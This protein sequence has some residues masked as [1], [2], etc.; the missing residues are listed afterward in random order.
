MAEGEGRWRKIP[1]SDPD[2]QEVKRG[3]GAL[4]EFTGF[5]VFGSSYIQWVPESGSEDHDGRW[6][7]M[8]DRKLSEVRS[9]FIEFL[10]DDRTLIPAL[11]LL[12]EGLD[13]GDLSE[14]LVRCSPALPEIPGSP[15]K[16]QKYGARLPS[17]RVARAIQSGEIPDELFGRLIQLHVENFRRKNEFFQKNLPQYL[18]RATQI[19]KEVTASGSIPISHEK[20]DSRIKGLNIRLGDALFARLGEYYGTFNIED[21]GI[22]IA[23]NIPSRMFEHAL[24]HEMLHALSGR[25]VIARTVKYEEIAL[26]S[27]EYQAQRGGLMFYTPLERFRW[28]NEAM[29]EGL[30]LK[31]LNKKWEDGTY[32]RERKLLDMLIARSGGAIAFKDFTD[33]YFEDYDPDLPEGPYI[34]AWES[35]SAKVNEVYGDS[36]LLALDKKIQEVGI[37]EALRK[38]ESGELDA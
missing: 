27:N 3:F 15:E 13:D 24:M 38:F 18:A 11:D 19:L 22:V 28:L 5:E 7:R 16:Q 25:T 2:Y 1:E 20:I 17:V 14:E 34:P 21:D 26:P 8:H 4:A 32:K 10:D 33:A 23:Q 30:T 9:R 36:F 6:K 35:L 29:T 12:K 31:A 37:G